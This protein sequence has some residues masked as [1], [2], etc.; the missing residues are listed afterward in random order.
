MSLQKLKQRA[1]ANAE[2]K[3]EYDKLESEFSF[4]D[5]LL[6]M[7]TKAGLTQEQVA[8]RMHTQKSNVSRLEKGKA[9]PSWSTLL[10]YAHACGFELTLKPQK[11]S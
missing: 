7:R 8:E 1:L 10:K 4:I 11:M 6:T 3:N 5:Q 9:N 2:V